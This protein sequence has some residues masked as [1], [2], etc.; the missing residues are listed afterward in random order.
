MLHLSNTI[1]EIKL[2]IFC[3]FLA[4]EEMRNGAMP[5]IAA[6]KA[7]SRIAQHYPNFFGGVIALNNKGEYGAACNG[8][9]TFPYYAANPTL[10]PKLHSVQCSNYPQYGYDETC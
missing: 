3:S 7:I 10:G 9:L 5:N 2:S 4:V 6:K 1:V 8:M